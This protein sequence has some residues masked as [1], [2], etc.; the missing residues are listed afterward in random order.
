M[1]GRD[2]RVQRIYQ[3]KPVKGLGEDIGMVTFAIACICIVI[4]EVGLRLETV[5]EIWGYQILTSVRTKL[6]IERRAMGPYVGPAKV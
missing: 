5:D 4:I 1:D 3:K 6:R 2:L